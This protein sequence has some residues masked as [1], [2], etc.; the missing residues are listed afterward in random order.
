MLVKRSVRLYDHNNG[1]ISPTS[2]VGTTARNPFSVLVAWSNSEF[3]ML[4]AGLTTR[5]RGQSATY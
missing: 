5:P 1:I 4:A 3:T 2:Y